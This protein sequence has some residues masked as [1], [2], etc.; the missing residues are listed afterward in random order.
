MHATVAALLL[1]RFVEDCGQDGLEL[2]I[3]QAPQMQGRQ[4][5]MVRACCVFSSSGEASA[6]PAGAAVLECSYIAPLMWLPPCCLS[7]AGAGSQE[8]C[9]ALRASVTDG[10]P[11]ICVPLLPSHTLI[12]EETCVKNIL[13]PKLGKN[14][15]VLDI[16]WLGSEQLRHEN[17]G[18]LR[19]P[20]AP[21][22]THP[23]A[24]ERGHGYE[25]N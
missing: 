8:G 15:Q 2:A 11:I 21:Q 9:A 16:K 14:T 17:V 1:Q 4:M 5:S 6:L 24:L 13:V 23:T 3:E 25:R 12:C 10:V 19:A 18:L 20:T 7:A 22:G